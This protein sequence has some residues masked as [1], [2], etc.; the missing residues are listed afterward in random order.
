[1]LGPIRRH[2]PALLL[3]ALAVVHPWL[4]QTMALHM[5]LEIPLLFAAGWLAARQAG[6][7]LGSALAGWNAHGLPAGLAA[8]LVLG[9]WMIPAALDHAVLDEGA[10]F[11]KVTSLVAAG[12]A[13]GASW[14]LAG[15]ILQAFF[16]ITTLWMALA[17]GLLYQAA[18][19]R[20]CSVYPADGQAAAGNAM[21]AWA[22]VALVA[23]VGSVARHTSRI[24]AGI[25]HD[26]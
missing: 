2:I 11:L 9:F 4:E 15:P 19:N 5:G 14:R 20:L 22:I 25:E 18:P 17:A 24:E 21:V 10:G 16:A 13:S 3:A 1:V 6:A 26:F 7:R 12:M 8:M 23:W